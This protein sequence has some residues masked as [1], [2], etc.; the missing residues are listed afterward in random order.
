MRRSE[1]RTNRGPVPDFRC[2]TNVISLVLANRA[3]IFSET[4]RYCAMSNGT[5][6]KS[7]RAVEALR[8][9]MDSS[10]LIEMARVSCALLGPHVAVDPPEGN[11]GHPTAFKTTTYA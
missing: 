4:T 7:E 8:S 5:S 10:G 11:P 1:R 6:G 2:R 3:A 9:S